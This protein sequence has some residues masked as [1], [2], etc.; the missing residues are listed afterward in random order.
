MLNWNVY[1]V[2]YIGNCYTIGI[3]EVKKTIPRQYNARKAEPYDPIPPVAK[4]ISKETWLICFDE[5]QVF[6]ED[7]I[8]EEMTK[9]INDRP[10]KFISLITFLEYLL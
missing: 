7:V 8:F 9:C 5:F 2:L 4:D 6:V 1:I 3:H 10:L